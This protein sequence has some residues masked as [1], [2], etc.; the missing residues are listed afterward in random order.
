MFLPG[1]QEKTHCKQCDI[2]YSE[3]EDP[4]AENPDRENP[5]RE[6]SGGKDTGRKYI[7][8]KL[9]KFSKTKVLKCKKKRFQVD[10]DWLTYY[11]S[12]DT[13]KEEVASLGESLFKREILCFCYSKSECNYMESKLILTMGALLSEDYYNRWVSMRITKAH[14]QSAL[15]K[16]IFS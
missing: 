4:D 14:V 7:G 13:L 10:S 8:K 16:N 12:N 1:D 5:D 15:K 6:N 9:F 11:G 2:E 3:G